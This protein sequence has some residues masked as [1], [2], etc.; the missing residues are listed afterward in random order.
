ML[1]PYL[2]DAVAVLFI[3]EWKEY[4]AGGTKTNKQ[5]RQQKPA[6]MEIAIDFE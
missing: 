2:C 3:A 6:E 1:V 4:D 5:I